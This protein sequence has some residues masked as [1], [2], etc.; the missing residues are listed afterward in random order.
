GP[1]R[2]R[3]AAAFG[4]RLGD[5]LAVEPDRLHRALDAMELQAITAPGDALEGAVTAFGGHI[6]PDSRFGLV[7]AQVSALELAALIGDA[8]PVV[9]IQRKCTGPPFAR[10]VDRG[11]AVDVD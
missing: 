2:L 5:R 1:R 10:E 11:K 6:E 7:E 9:F 4:V 8:Q 3:A